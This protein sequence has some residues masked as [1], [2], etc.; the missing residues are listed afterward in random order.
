MFLGFPQFLQANTRTV[1][2]IRQ[3]SFAFTSSPNH[4]PVVVSSLDP[5]SLNVERFEGTLKNCT[6]QAANFDRKAL[7]SK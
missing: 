7:N 4:Y 5:K 3:S 6:S 1:T 2:Q